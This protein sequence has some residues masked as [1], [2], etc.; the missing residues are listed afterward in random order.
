VSQGNGGA[1]IVGDNGQVYLS[2]LTAT[3]QLTAQW[4]NAKEQR[5]IADYQL[6]EQKAAQMA[7]SILSAECQ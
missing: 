6:D 7:V 1:G 3:G 4:G 5:C 2:G